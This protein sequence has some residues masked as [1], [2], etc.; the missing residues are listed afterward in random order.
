MIRILFFFI[1]TT[2]LFSFDEALAQH[3]LE[4]SSKKNIG[5]S[6]YLQHCARCHHADRIGISGPPLLPRFL[7]RYKIKDLVS[8]IRNGFDQTLM[9]KFDNLDTASLLSI[10][11]YIKSPVEMKNYEWGAARIDETL[12]TFDDPVNPLPIKNMANITPVVERDG[13]K[14]WIM[15]DDRVLARFPMTNVHGGIKYQFPDAENIFVPTRDG[16]VE[17]YSLKEGRRVAKIRPCVYLR[18]VSLSRDGKYGFATCLLPEQMVIFDTATLK[19]KK[20]VHLDGK[21][22]ALYDLYSDDRMVFTYRDKAKVGYVDTKSFSIEYRETEEP[23]ED[24]FIDPFDRYLIATARRGKLLRVY[25]LKSLKKVFEHPMTGMPH[26]FSATYWYRKGHFYFAT[27]HLR[28]DFITIWE[29]YNWKLVK[30]LP[31]GGDGFFV[32]THPQTPYLWVDNGSDELI[33][34]SKKD[35]SIRKM[36]PRKG[37]QYI[38]AEFSGDGRYTYLSIYTHDGSIEVW[39]TQSLK[40]IKSYPADIPVG[41]YNFICKNRRFYPMLFGQEIVREK[42][43][44]HNDSREI[45]ESVLQGKIELKEFELRSVLD[46]LKIL[47][48][49]EKKKK[50]H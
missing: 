42:F 16:W 31:I 44:D 3:Q 47:S 38:H 46:Y 7:R 24:F 49:E 45:M 2:A 36:V 29:M 25:D 5:R 37:K 34:V 18:N 19:S 26:L 15:E 50:K 39:D 8:M 33:L 12:T 11:R 17:K 28:S 20:V 35:Y 30:K 6:L 14:V 23:I 48:F 27:P 32:K 4:A 40:K 21:V 13:G 43:S 9:P 41:K 1:F 10:A 22:S